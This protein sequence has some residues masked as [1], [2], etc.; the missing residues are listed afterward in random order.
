MPSKIGLNQ[1]A[2]HFSKLRNDSLFMS[3]RQ[4]SNLRPPGPKPG[5]LA[6]L[7]HTPYQKRFQ[8]YHKQKQKSTHFSRRKANI[9]LQRGMQLQVLNP[10]GRSAV[11]NGD[12]R[13]STP[14]VRLPRH[15]SAARVHIEDSAVLGHQRHMRM[16]EQNHIARFLPCAV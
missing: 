1:K 11:R 5:A 14:A 9:Y 16:S 10:R 4:D 3:G 7:S 6:K 12:D 13:V 8:Q 15:R 2:S